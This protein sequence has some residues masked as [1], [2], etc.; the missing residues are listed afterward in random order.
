MVK[1]FLWTVC[2]DIWQPNLYHSF[3]QSYVAFRGAGDRL[4]IFKGRKEHNIL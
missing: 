4:V 2:V 1:D 3:H